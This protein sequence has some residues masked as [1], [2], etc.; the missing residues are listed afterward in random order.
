M[1][2]RYLGVYLGHPAPELNIGWT[3]PPSW[4]LGDRPITCRR[5]KSC[6]LGKRSCGLGRR[7]L[8]ELVKEMD[9]YKIGVCAGQEIQW[10]GKGT[11]MKENYVI[12]YSGC[13]SD[14]HEFGTGFYI[15]RH[16]I[17]RLLDSEPVGEKN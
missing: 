10:P 8:D 15:S 9:N 1:G 16:V 3:G 5:K 17:D 6:V 2:T 11:V 12:L 7:A 13:K 4:G 14:R